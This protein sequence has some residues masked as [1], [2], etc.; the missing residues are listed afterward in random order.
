M[1]GEAVLT[2]ADTEYPLRPSFEA[3][4]AFE[5]A[6]GMTRYQLA[7]AANSNALTLET[8]GVVAAELIRAHA[9]ANEDADMARVRPERI[10]QLI[11]EAGSFG[12]SL[13]LALVLMR[14][15]GG[16][17]TIEG[18]A[19]KVGKNIPAIPTAA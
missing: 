2:L 12:I 13:Q 16:G 4:V 14:A 17:Y 11:Y 8:M 19:K 7:D 10:A 18:E 5:R 3:I 9:K 6:T 1:R 15:A